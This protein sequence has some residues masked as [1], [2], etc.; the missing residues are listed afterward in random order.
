MKK[1]IRL[2]TGL[3]M[4]FVM[5]IALSACKEDEPVKEPYTYE[6]SGDFTKIFISFYGDAGTSRGFSFFTEVGTYENDCVVHIDPA[7]ADEVAPVFDDSDNIIVEATSEKTVGI[8]PS[9]QR[10]YAVCSTLTA[11]QKYFYRVGSQTQ[12]KWSLWG[13][14]TTDDAND[15]FSFLHIT[16]SQSVT[17]EE[18]TNFRNTVLKAVDTVGLPEFIITTGDLVEF[19]YFEEQW[20]SYYE[21]VGDI[22]MKLTLAPA[23]GNHEFLP[24]PLYYHFYIPAGEPRAAYY[25]YEYG[26]ALFVMLD[27]NNL[28]DKQMN[29]L[30]AVLEDS[31]KEW[32]IL[33][34]HAASFS[35]G[36]HADDELFVLPF[37][38]KI[39]PIVG[40][41][42]VDLVMNGHDHLYCRT[43]PVGGDSAAAGYEEK[44][45]ETMEEGYDKTVY[46]NPEGAIFVMNRCVGS[47][48]Y[49]KVNSLNDHLL[50][51]YDPYKISIPVFSNVTINGN[52]LT[53]TAYE[54]NRETGEVTVLDCFE[55]VKD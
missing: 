9:A 36:S 41:Y 31:D 33:S 13:S 52:T 38:E 53:Y 49:G 7:G 10:H 30:K 16:D 28:S 25:A 6:P 18:F 22:F 11:G 39:V 44:R 19:G 35:T 17:D 51:K 5:L 3:V 48:F 29:W 40:E 37:K 20:D 1:I 12:D 26:N 42:G 2:M 45:T 24:T 34:Y 15:S 27:S 4:L 46:V 8:L 55:L 50:E 54:H 14:F 32:K 23:N 43:V 47:K 21:Y